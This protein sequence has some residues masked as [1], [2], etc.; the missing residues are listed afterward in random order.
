MKTIYLTIIACMFALHMSGQ[1]KPIEL[2]HYVF[3]EFLEGEILMKNGVKKAALLNYNSLS[4]EM[5]FIER[6]VKLAIADDELKRIDTMF[7]EGRRFVVLN[8]DIVEV[9]L[10]KNSAKVFALHKC[11]V[12]RPGSRTAYGG[13]S[14]STTSTSYGQITTGARIYELEL[15]DGYEADPFIVYWIIK[16]GEHTRLSN[17][18]Q[19]RRFYRDNHDLWNQFTGQ[20]DVNF[21]NSREVRQLIEYLEGY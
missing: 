18:R 20:N 21:N 13:T 7:I 14:H 17:L 15:P 10:D 12:K 19:L 3:P 11:R 6:G 9:L 2:S 5:V 8:D 1:V 16:N 4:E